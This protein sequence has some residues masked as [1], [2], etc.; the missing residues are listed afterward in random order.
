MRKHR[1]FPRVELFL[2]FSLIIPVS[3]T[4]IFAMSKPAPNGKD[5]EEEIPPPQPPPSPPLHTTFG[6][7]GV[8]VRILFDT[9]RLFKT[10]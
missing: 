10:Y 7:R 6:A 1:N 3:P 8:L 2:H 4:A 9:T 5:D